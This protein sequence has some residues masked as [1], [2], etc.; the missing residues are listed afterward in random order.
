MPVFDLTAQPSP[1]MVA[2]FMELVTP[3]PNSGCWL[4]LGGT[5]STGY[6]WFY[7]MP[8]QSCRAHRFSYRALRGPLSAR[9]QV[10]HR[11]DMRCCVNP[12]HFF[13]GDHAVNL[14]DMT[15]KGRRYRRIQISE[16]G[17]ILRRRADGETFRSIADAYGVSLHCIFNIVNKINGGSFAL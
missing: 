2:A 9:D 4:W 11:C 12:A 6:G 14:A 8:N 5:S 7:P 17:A 13:L 10:C 16:H 3:E 15:H 1:A